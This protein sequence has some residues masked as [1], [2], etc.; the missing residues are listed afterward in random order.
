M[1]E[2]V[3]TTALTGSARRTLARCPEVGYV[4]FVRTDADR[5]RFTQHSKA[6]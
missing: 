3:V 2:P 5:L 1:C 4:K 6:R